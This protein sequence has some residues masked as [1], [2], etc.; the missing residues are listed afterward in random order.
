MIGMSLP[1][2]GLWAIPVLLV[3]T[4]TFVTEA[5]AGASTP[6]DGLNL[7]SQTGEFVGQG[8]AYSVPTVTFDPND[9][10]YAQGVEEFVARDGTDEFTVDLSALQ[11]SPLVVGTYT[12]AHQFSSASSP[13]IN[14]S[15]DARGCDT[16]TG[17]FTVY[18]ATYDSGGTP[19]T[20][21]AE[22]EQQC[23]TAT[24]ELL[25]AIRFNSAASM[26]A[27]P[28]AQPN[29]IIPDYSYNPNFGSV[30]VGD[31]SDPL[32]VTMT[33]TGSGTEVVSGFAES[34]EAPDDFVVDSNCTSLTTGQ[35]CTIQ[36]TFLPGAAGSRSVVISP[37]GTE[38]NPP[39][40]SVQGTGTIG[41]YEAGSDGS[42][43]DFGDADDYGDASGLPLAAPIVSMVAT[44]GGYGYWLLGADGG[45]FS[46]G[47][48]QFY[49]STGAM[50]LNKPVV[51]LAPTPD[52]GGYW[53]V[54]SDG[55]IF[56]FGD[57]QFYGSTGALR[58]TK[59][60]VG[61]AP[62]PDG[63]GYWLVASDGA[64]FSFGDA[65]TVENVDDSSIDNIVA[66][67]GTAPPTV[68]S[69]LGIPAIRHR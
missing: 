51:G 39:T 57:A 38:E 45:I 35:S 26:P 30:R 31:A 16:T 25:G 11:G 15:G 3:S 6:T 23:G 50:R 32:E 46:F 58:L 42:V 67:S 59:P 21:A 69:L 61:I 55:G 44:P 52:G 14:V 53:L 41:F 66:I 24:P 1:R 56:S 8:L 20:F 62:T 9:S 54:A 13:G 65:A 63:A 68:Q 40:I 64:V 22:F 18:D 43:Y 47:N 10:N 60:I 34:G 28:A 19:L 17:S 2:M 33:N 37:T 29:L 12:G 7:I 49:G 27:L 4:L 48:A 5:T 36:V